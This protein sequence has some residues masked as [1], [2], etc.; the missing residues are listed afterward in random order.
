MN[1]VPCK[2]WKAGIRLKVLNKNPVPNP[3]KTPEVSFQR[4]MGWKFSEII[5]V[6]SENHVKHENTVWIKCKSCC[7]I[8]CNTYSGQY[9]SVIHCGSNYVVNSLLVY[10]YDI[11]H[12]A[13]DRL[14]SHTT[15]S[16][17]HVYYHV[18]INTTWGVCLCVI[19]SGE[20][21]IG[22]LRNRRWSCGEGMWNDGW[23]IVV[24]A[25]ILKTNTSICCRIECVMIW[26]V[27]VWLIYIFGYETVTLEAK[28]HDHVW[29][30][31]VTTLSW[32]GGSEESRLQFARCSAARKFKLIV[33][34]MRTVFKDYLCLLFISL[35]VSKS[36]TVSV[37]ER[38]AVTP[39][40]LGKINTKVEKGRAFSLYQSF[41]KVAC[42]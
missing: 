40:I 27:T 12:F 7:I 8:Y 25:V 22:Y 11:L 37:V 29:C 15:I 35:L 24:I 16:G 39:V 28:V 3:Q 1:S 14:S 32:K 31:C 23:S 10:V 19:V 18:Q 20:R 41:M 42:G 36:C 30:L 6:Y 5:Y 9:T 21:A 33:R 17:F 4:S 2:L 38:P 26:S 13:R 34:N